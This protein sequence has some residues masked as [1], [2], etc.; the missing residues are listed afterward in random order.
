MTSV[1][2]APF[3]RRAAGVTGVE[4]HGPYVLLN[5]V[6]PDGPHPVAGQFYML[7]TETGWGGGDDGRPFLPRALSFAR[8]ANVGNGIQ[9]TF[10][11]EEVGPGTRRLAAC[12][13]AE[14]LL[15]AGPFGNGFAVDPD[16]GAVL[17]AGGI[18]LAPITAL[19]TEIAASGGG[20]PVVLLGMRTAKHALAAS[21]MGVS[22]TLA[23]DDGSAGRH[24]LVTEL[25]SE[26]LVENRDST[27]YSC[28]PPPMLEAVR[29]LCAENAVPCLLAMESTMACG[30]GACYGCVVPTRDG[31][32]RLCVDGPVLDGEV[33]E[34]AA[35]AGAGH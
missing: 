17:V 35:A 4:R 18:G 30:Y 8:A 23:T 34:T 27:V 22:G 2:T 14:N 6:D 5:A 20:E 28:G 10:L 19:A 7:Q 3:G 29:A 15:V 32:K 25:L 33:L 11:L 24:C 12:G 21:A 1:P 9:L 13:P 31:Y 16:R 26:E